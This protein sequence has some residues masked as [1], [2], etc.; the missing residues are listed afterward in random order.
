M[1][2]HIL[3]VENYLFSLLSLYYYHC[4]YYLYNYY[5]YVVVV[6]INDH[7]HYYYLNEFSHFLY[8]AESVRAKPSCR[9]NTDASISARTDGIVNGALLA[10]V[11][12][13]LLH[14]Q[15][16]LRTHRGPSSAAF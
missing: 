6:N 7:Y 16:G 5:Y 10:S 15:P 4:R 13:R 12:S 8:N 1:Q 2:F 14:K 3:S 9:F 11:D